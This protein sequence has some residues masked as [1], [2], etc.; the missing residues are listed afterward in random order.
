V[1]GNTA[2]ASA[3]FLPDAPITSITLTYTVLTTISSFQLWAAAVTSNISGIVR[4][5]TG[6]AAPAGTTVRLIDGNGIS[7]AT[8]APLA[9]GTYSFANVVAAADIVEV[10]PPAGFEVVGDARQPA[11]ASAGD[12]FGLDFV[13]RA[14]PPSS[15]TTSTSVTQPPTSPPPTPEP[16]P[17]TTNAPAAP[18]STTSAGLPATGSSTRRVT[19]PAAIA[20]LLGLILVVVAR[21]RAGSPTS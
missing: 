7:I 4:L 14:I 9:D 3:W 13:L 16:G 17:T 20:G 1:G 15:T 12:V 10:V 5:D 8:A 2:G 19:L 21:R 11:D 6:A 18:S